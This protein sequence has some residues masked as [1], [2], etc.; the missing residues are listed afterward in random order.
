MVDQVHFAAFAGGN[1]GL[2]CL[3]AENAEYIVPQLET[4]VA[5]RGSQVRAHV[6]S[7]RF[8]SDEDAHCFAESAGDG[9]AHLGLHVRAHRDHLCARRLPFKRFLSEL[10]CCA[11]CADMSSYEVPSGGDWSV[12]RSGAVFLEGV[13]RVTIDH[14]LF[15]APGGNG[16]VVSRFARAV[17]ITNNEFVRCATD[18]A[19]RRDC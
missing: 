11:R 18:R 3:A 15:N 13:A 1:H 8:C 2:S 5:I 14:N 16:V 12:H 17:S 19:N 6:Q 10:A 7:E 4:I 9:S